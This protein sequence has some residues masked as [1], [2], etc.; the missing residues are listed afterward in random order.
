MAIGAQP[1]GFLAAPN[2][3]RKSQ[4]TQTRDA[5]G[6]VQASNGLLADRA[7][8]NYN[9]PTDST[10]YNTLQSPYGSG[11]YGGGENMFA[12]NESRQYGFP[13]RERGGG[14]RNIFDMFPQWNN[15]PEDSGR[16]TQFANKA[17][18]DQW[19]AQRLEKFYNN[20]PETARSARG[21]PSWWR[22]G[23]PPI[24]SDETGA[25]GGVGTG[26]DVGPVYGGGQ[27]NDA[28]NQTLNPTTQPVT[29]GMNNPLSQ[30]LNTLR[31]I[32][33][34]QDASKFARGM[35]EANNAQLL[36]SQKARAGAGLDWSNLGFGDYASNLKNQVTNQNTL[37][38][39]LQGLI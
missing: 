32:Y 17:V 5:Y 3:N 30:Q 21:I 39:L 15:L 26:I 6:N 19:A 18:Y 7:R 9:F 36:A 25:G 16:R 33:G 31:G 24:Y 22:P 35:A 38:S 12:A 20:L 28:Y 29:D 14:S 34:S 8:I 37:L 1:S 27:A 4:F 23:M 13:M 10:N 2:Q 11:G